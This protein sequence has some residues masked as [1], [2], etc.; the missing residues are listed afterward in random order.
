MARLI[1]TAGCAPTPMPCG[2]TA[3]PP[4]RWP[5]SM[6]RRFAILPSSGMRHRAA[7]ALRPRQ[8][9]SAAETSPK[10]ALSDK[11][12]KLSPNPMLLTTMVIVHQKETKLPNERVKLYHKAV[13]VLAQRWQQ[14][15][16]LPIAPRF[17]RRSLPTAIAWVP[18][19]WNGWPTRPIAPKR[20]RRTCPALSCWG[21]WKSQRRTFWAMRGWPRLFSTTAPTGRVGQGATAAANIPGELRLFPHLTFQNIWPVAI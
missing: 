9:T 20:R 21:F 12:D 3:L 18:G 17:D 2:W 14:Q 7:G 1:V 13:E 10:V 16:G 6:R 11:L 19:N 4:R 8:L 5:P 15:R